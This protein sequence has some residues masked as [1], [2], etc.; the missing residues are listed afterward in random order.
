MANPNKFAFYKS[1]LHEDSPSRHYPVVPSSSP[2]EEVLYRDDQGLSLVSVSSESDYQKSILQGYSGHCN[3]S[4]ATAS[5]TDFEVTIPT[6]PVS[7]DS[8]N[9]DP[10]EHPQTCQ[11]TK[12][13]AEADGECSGNPPESRQE[14]ETSSG[15]AGQGI[16]LDVPTPKVKLNEIWEVDKSLPNCAIAS[17]GLA[18]SCMLD[19]VQAL[20]LEEMDATT[21]PEPLHVASV[22]AGLHFST[23]H[24]KPVIPMQPYQYRCLREGVTYDRS[25]VGGTLNDQVLN[26]GKLNEADNAA[27]QYAVTNEPTRIVQ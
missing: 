11:N 21:I 2:T 23:Q 1:M 6:S 26:L 18:H 19:E 15:K 5:G 24:G 10:T 8:T 4:S 13:T 22:Y 7:I 14:G 27:L 12:A 25:L 3:G 16:L 20:T 9:S 17:R